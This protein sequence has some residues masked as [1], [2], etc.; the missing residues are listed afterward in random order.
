MRRQC[1]FETFY[2]TL[3]IYNIHK[4]KTNVLTTYEV[5]TLTMFMNMI[6]SSFHLKYFTL[7][8]Q[9]TQNRFNKNS[10]FNMINASYNF[11][12]II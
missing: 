11:L 6:E 7:S 1:D 4:F 12:K 8:S 10:R 5:S 9:N 3:Y 2:C